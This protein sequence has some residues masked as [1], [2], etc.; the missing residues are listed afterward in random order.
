[1]WSWTTDLAEG[2]R[3]VSDLTNVLQGVQYIVGDLYR[4]LLVCQEE[5]SDMQ[6][7]QIACLLKEKLDN[8]MEMFLDPDN[9]PIQ[10]ALFMDPR[11]NN[12]TNPLFSA[13]QKKKIIGYLE[14]VKKRIDNLKGRDVAAAPEPAPQVGQRKSK[15]E[16]FQRG[17]AKATGGQEIRPK[18]LLEQLEDLE[19]QDEPL[20]PLPLSRIIGLYC[21][22]TTLN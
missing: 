21:P 11:Y 3:P 5:L 18:T 20:G 13:A 17:L 22:T 4:D 2:L 14:V 15:L 9:L 10:A 6:G 8:R 12:K 1:M 16:L 19:N 7:N